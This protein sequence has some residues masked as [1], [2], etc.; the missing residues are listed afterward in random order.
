MAGVKRTQT[1]GRGPPSAPANITIYL[2]L[3]FNPSEVHASSGA[4]LGRPLFLVLFHFF[5]LA[6]VTNKG[7]S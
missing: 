1:K 7:L 3:F 2:R 5:S 4:N 6:V